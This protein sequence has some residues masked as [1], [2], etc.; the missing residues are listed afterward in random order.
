MWQFNYWDVPLSIHSTSRSP[1]N[2]LT[3]LN[4]AGKLL[5]ERAMETYGIDL[6]KIKKEGV[7]TIKI[8]G[9]VTDT[10]PYININNLS[11]F[12]IEGM[13]QIFLDILTDEFLSLRGIKRPVY[14]AGFVEFRVA[15]HYASYYTFLDD[16]R[17]S[18]SIFHGKYPTY[19]KS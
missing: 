10:Y 17:F 19:F 1:L 14:F 5:R 16:S 4:K 13:N 2:Y 11:D 8:E 6:T 3:L 7:H 9:N 15:N 18:G 12:E